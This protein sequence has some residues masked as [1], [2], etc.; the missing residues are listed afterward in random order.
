M[1]I[2]LGLL[3][4]LLVLAAWP[5]AAAPSAVTAAPP[6]QAGLARFDS[7]PCPYPEG[8]IP[9]HE[10]VDCGYLTVPE[11]RAAASARTI[12]LAVAILRSPNP[13]PVR[14]PVLYLSGGPGEG[15]LDFIGYWLTRAQT[16]RGNRD[17]ILLDQ[18]GTGY[19]EPN[20]DCWEFDALSAATRADPPAS[21]EWI[22]RQVATAEQCRDRLL[23]EGANLTAYNTAQSAADVKDLR[24]A[25]GIFEWNLYGHSYG[26][27]LALTVLRDYPGGV[28][29]VVLSSPLPPQAGWWEEAAANAERAFNQVFT[30]CAR[31]RVCAT[32]F[33]DLQR[34]A[35]DVVDTLNA[36]PLIVSVP[37]PAT[38]AP[39]PQL[40]DG[41]G[42]LSGGFSAMYESEL[43]PYLPLAV[44]Q[45]HAGNYAVVEGF[46]AA[47][48]STPVRGMWYSVMCHDEAPF[49]DPA[50]VAASQAAHPRY[51]AFSQFEAVQAVCAIWGAG[52]AGPLEDEPVRSAVPALLLH[53]AYDPIHPPA[54]GQLA[55][56]TLSN[57]TFILLPASGHGGGLGPCGQALAAEFIA[58][59]GVAPGNDCARAAAPAWVTEAYINPG[60]YRLAS[61]LL[62]QRDWLRALPFAL[63]GLMFV[64]ALL[65]WPV[66]QLRALRRRPA[67]GEWLGRWLAA[68][69]A[70]LYLSFAVLLL[71]VIN[72]TANT[73]PYLLLFGLPPENAPLFIV[74][75]VAG[76]LSLGLAVM[77]YFAWRDRYWS[78]AGRIYFTLVMAAALGFFWLLLDWGL[79]SF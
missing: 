40:V 71:I 12:R 19:S 29:S 55:A 14:D 66:D 17:I 77:A 8:V 46:A 18:R 61:G 27:R 45:V 50:V 59:P 57:S 75:W 65:L 43:I 24:V 15:A 13:A 68:L 38:G 67:R 5:A 73:Q 30:G 36:S 31:D 20:L 25:L 16:L 44:A 54:W 11:D 49:N 63:C 9:A 4:G 28:R 1:K 41:Q 7:A 39:V 51:A 64:S 22:E 56:S 26:T 10:R 33:P 37:D 35:F 62:L 52:E 42:F 6:P 2:R 79:V 76:A 69:V 74:P 58:Q 72:E 53:G 48:G 34:R 60:V 21:D 78:L 3:A 23:A 47:L 70:A 32:A